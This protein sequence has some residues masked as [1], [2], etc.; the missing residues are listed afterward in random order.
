MMYAEI[1]RAPRSCHCLMVPEMTAFSGFHD[2]LVCTDLEEGVRE[3]NHVE[4][5]TNKTN[6]YLKIQDML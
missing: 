5:D 4:T 3:C 6:T 2:S 1:R